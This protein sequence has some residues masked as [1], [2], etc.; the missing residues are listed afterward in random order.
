MEVEKR[1]LVNGG[2]KLPIGYRFHPT[3]QELIL[4][5]LLPKAF[6]S[7]LP[8]SIIPVFDVF[9]SHP[10]T[11]PG[12][13]KEKQRYFFC[14]KRREVSS[15]DQHRIKTSSSDGY[16]KSYG[17]ERQIISCGRTVGIRRTLAFYETNKSSSNCNKTRWS[18]TEYCLAGFASTKVFGEWAVYSVYERKVSKGRMQR[19]AKGR[20]D[21]E[22]L[23][24]IHFTIGSDHETGPP[25][26]S[27]PTSADESG[28]II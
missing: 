3:E 23:S 15:K 19:K 5:Y 17:K 4:H 11:F 16:W 14:K 26:P 27:P 20:D 12:D 28:S 24:C 22:D 8:S 9:F 2:M 13:Q 7:P 21:E 18:M 6:A 25:P 10:L 1:T